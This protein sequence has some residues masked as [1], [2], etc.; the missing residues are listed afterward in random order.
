[1]VKQVVRALSDGRGAPRPF[2]TFSR[3]QYGE[4]VYI[5]DRKIPVAK[6]GRI[7]IPKRIMDEYGLEGPD[8][9]K[10]VVVDFASSP[11]YRT[12][13]QEYAARIILPLPEDLTADTG[14]KPKRT[15]IH[16]PSDR[17][18]PRDSPDMDWSA[19]T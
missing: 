8:G 16:K 2:G 5:G 1:M 7:I 9:R 6:D 10:R 19:L 17:L 12:G 4:Y 18:I 14:D 11:E 13:K 3:K 15:V